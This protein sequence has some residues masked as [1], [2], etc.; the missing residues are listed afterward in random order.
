MFLTFAG[1]KLSYKLVYELQLASNLE[2]FILESKMNVCRLP[3]MAE[4]AA[5]GFVPP[6][7]SGFLNKIK[8]APQRDSRHDALKIANQKHSLICPAR[9]R[10]GPRNSRAHKYRRW[11]IR[12]TI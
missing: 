8:E 2:L 6:P 7:G 4:S 11:H 10:V 12:G 3:A 1:C 9:K 5:P